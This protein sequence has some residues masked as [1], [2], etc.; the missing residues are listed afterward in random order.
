MLTTRELWAVSMILEIMR[1]G[2]DIVSKREITQSI[3]ISTDYAEQILRDLARGGAVESLRGVH[4]GFR[5]SS[6]THTVWDVV[7]RLR[8][9]PPSVR[10]PSPEVIGIQ[11]DLARAEKQAMQEMDLQL[12]LM[13]LGNGSGI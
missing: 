8:A 3:G 13:D 6:G 4:G 1:S 7:K 5:V 12:I 9:S 11:K 10:N 2:Q